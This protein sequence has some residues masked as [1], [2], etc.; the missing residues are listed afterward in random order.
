[1]NIHAYISTRN[2]VSKEEGGGEEEEEEHPE[3]GKQ[4]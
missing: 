1:M 4:Q 2:S 3:Y